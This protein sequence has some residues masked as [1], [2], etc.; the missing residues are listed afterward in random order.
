MAHE[1]FARF[2][3][4]GEMALVV[5]VLGFAA[6][7]VQLVLEARSPRW[8]AAARLPFEDDAAARREETK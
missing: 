5:A 1:L 2:S 7:L 4:F 3:F 8:L 6:L